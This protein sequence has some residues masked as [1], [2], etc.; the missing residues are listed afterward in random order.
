M[1]HV[2]SLILSNK[3]TDLEYM[4]IN[5]FMQMDYDVHLYSYEKVEILPQYKHKIFIRD[6]KVIMP[7]NEM[8]IGL[9]K[10]IKSED[11]NIFDKGIEPVIHIKELSLKFRLLPLLWKRLIITDVDI[12]EPEI[13][14]TR[15]SDGR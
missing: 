12:T 5:S 3:L 15:D 1:K 10:G 4:S 8:K 7:Y 11:I 2:S 13:V 6:A 9:F 14:I